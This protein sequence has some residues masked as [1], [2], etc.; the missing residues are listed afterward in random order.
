MNKEVYLKSTNPE[1][2]PDI[3][4]VC[5]VIPNDQVKEYVKSIPEERKQVAAKTAPVIA[6]KGIEGEVIKTDI[7]CHLAGREYILGEEQTTVKNRDGVLDVV[8]TN[9]NSTSNESYVVKGKKFI[10]TYTPNDDT[11]FSPI[12]EERELAQVDE[13]VIITTAWGSEAVCL[14]GSYIVT[15]NAEENDFNVL[16]QEAYEKTYQKVKHGSKIIAA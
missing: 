15:Y 4:V 8:V 1:L 11:T 5:K 12:P 3:K 9:T 14:K 6:R 2:Y 10:E 7:K 13:N 16:E